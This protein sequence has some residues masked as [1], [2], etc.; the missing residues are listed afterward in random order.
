MG[1]I[2]ELSLLL[3]FMLWPGALGAAALRPDETPRAGK[4]ALPVPAPS[5]PS[6][7]HALRIFARLNEGFERIYWER[8]P[9]LVPR[10]LS[11]DGPMYPV[12]LAE[13]DQLRHDRVRSRT[14]FMSK[15]LQ[16]GE[17][18]RR[19]F[20]VRERLLLI[21]RF[22]DRTG[23]DITTSEPL[24]QKVRWTIVRRHGRWV[25]HNVFLEVSRVARVKA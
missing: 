7:R 18:R 12:A 22:L 10:F 3:S 15:G 14:R 25:I 17:L 11:E 21:P 19:S 20:V 2:R 5:V 13:V 4:E 1:R 24:V 9:T 23:V 8:D 16:V 6:A